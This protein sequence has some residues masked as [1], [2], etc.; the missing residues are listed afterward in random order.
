MT[1]TNP[2]RTAK[3][4]RLIGAVTSTKMAKTVTVRVSR[5]IQHPKY[6]KTYSV[7]RAFKAHEI[8]GKIRVGDVVEIEETRPL[9]AHKNW[10][11]V[12]VVTPAAAT[13]L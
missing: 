9:S 4:R 1:T 5:R 7:S 6:G 2:T 12:R 13:A 11:V 10:R 8:T 3:R